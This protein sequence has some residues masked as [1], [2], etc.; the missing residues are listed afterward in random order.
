M[1]QNQAVIND[2]ID[3]I[4]IFRSLYKYKVSIILCTFIFGCTACITALTTPK[5]FQAEVLI[6]SSQGNNDS[7]KLSSLASR[8]AGLAAI[9]GINLVSHDTN[10]ESSLALLE[11]RKFLLS[12]INQENLKP[13]LFPERWD[14]D[15]DMWFPT[16]EELSCCLQDLFAEE[17]EKPAVNTPSDTAAY[18]R[19]KGMLTVATLQKSGLI[20]VSVKSKDPYLAANMANRLVSGLNEYLRDEAIAES[21][22]NMHYLEQEISNTSLVEFQSILYKMIESEASN[23]MLAK[24]QKEY[25]FKVIDPAFVPES[26]VGPRSAPITSVGILMGLLIGCTQALIRIAIRSRLRPT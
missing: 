20:R 6:T 3:L 15:N 25:A 4:E 7:D 9:A 10:I 8:Y 11:S 17:E 5:T 1:A 2:E 12:L 22:A 21:K 23:I 16:E 13:V 24:V 14:S 19:L 18:L 26:A